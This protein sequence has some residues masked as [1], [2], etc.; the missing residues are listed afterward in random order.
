MS[1]YSFAGL[2]GED[3]RIY[4]YADRVVNGFHMDC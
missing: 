4:I 2:Y 1:Y 3:A